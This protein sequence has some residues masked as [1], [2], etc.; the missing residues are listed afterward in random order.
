MRRS[1]STF[2]AI[3]GGELRE[4]DVILDK[5]T[6]ILKGS[7]SRRV[8]IMTVA[9]NEPDAAILKY[10]FLF[11]SKGIKRVESIDVM[12]RKDPLSKRAVKRSIRHQKA[13]GD[14]S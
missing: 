7:S 9:T 3:G 10:N 11:R 12:E 4:S 5:L 14:T 1:R 2:V 6:E 13:R 8:L